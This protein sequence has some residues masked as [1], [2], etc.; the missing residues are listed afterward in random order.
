MV[1]LE[2]P[3]LKLGLPLEY[4]QH[5]RAAGRQIRVDTFRH[6]G[7]RGRRTKVREG[8]AEGRKQQDGA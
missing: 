4:P 3:E 7:L 1:T 6:V 2:H 5:D 8:D